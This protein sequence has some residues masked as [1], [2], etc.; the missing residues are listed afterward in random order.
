MFPTA[1][2]LPTIL[3]EPED[4]TLFVGEAFTLHCT[5]AFAQHYF[6]LRDGLTIESSAT[7]TI[8]FGVGLVVSNASAGDSGL[9]QCYAVNNNG[10]VA[11]ASATVHV[12]EALLTCEGV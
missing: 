2:S 9:Y 12:I 4:V 7:T 1:V 5:A 8:R 3:N 6:W 11:S 10:A